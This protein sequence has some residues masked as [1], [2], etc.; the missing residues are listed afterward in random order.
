MK[1]IKLTQSNSNPI[2][3]NRDHITNVSVSTKAAKGR[4]K[5]VEYLYY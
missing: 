4:D 3:F 1:L 5:A 2:Y